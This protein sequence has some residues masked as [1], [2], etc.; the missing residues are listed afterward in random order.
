MA[1]DKNDHHEHRQRVKE[2]FL[3]SGMKHMPPHKVLEFLL[4]YV[5]RVKDTNVTA[6]KLI[7]RFGSLTG[8]FHAPYELL[9]ETKGIGKET[10]LFIKVLAA[11]VEV[12][13]TD[14]YAMNNVIKTHED[15]KNYMRYRFLS[16]SVE[17]VLLTCLG[18]G[19]KVIFSG[20]IAEGSLDK[21]EISPSVVAK[22]CV[23]ANATKAIIAHNHPGGF[24][25][26]SR[27]DVKATSDISS[28]LNMLGVELVDHIIVASDGVYSMMENGMFPG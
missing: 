13:V 19:D 16:D 14:H 20:Q 9:L 1:N 8:V 15:A 25:L 2:E 23:K 12:F 26:P 18:P 11:F 7:D 21:V 6:H 10:A 28:H 3:K 5:I 27:M 4:F 17:V 24:C 22:L